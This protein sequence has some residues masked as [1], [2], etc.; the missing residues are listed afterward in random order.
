MHYAV[1]EGNVNFT[2]QKGP[3]LSA[4]AVFVRWQFYHGREAEDL[5]AQLRM[6]CTGS[7]ITQPVCSCVPVQ[8]TS[9]FS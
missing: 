2:I 4:Q 1:Q 5:Q 8:P 9:P 3:E 6:A 7:H